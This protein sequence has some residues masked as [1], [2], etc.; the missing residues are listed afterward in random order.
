MTYAAACT[1]RLR[2]G[3]AVLIL[4]MC[5]PVPL[6]KSLGSLDQLSR[7]RLEIGLATGGGRRPFAAFGADPATF[8]ARFTEQVRLMKALWSE[9]T[10]TFAGKFWQLEDAAMEPK[11]LQRPHPP[12][13]FG[14][15]HPAAVRR[16]VRHAGGFFGAGSQTTEQFAGQV[17]VVRQE[18]DRQERDPASFRIAKRVYVAV[19]DD[20]GR[21]RE[22]M[23]AAL[24]Q[25]YGYFNLPNLLPVA[26]TGP[27]GAC[28]DG[29]RAVI[30]AGAQLILLTTLGDE[31]EQMERLAAQVIPGLG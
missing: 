22:R 29:L 2:I 10:V 12:L 19:D 11:P 30:E 20:P 25:L 26:V 3:A 18:L 9:P 13:W 27:P 23:S 14:G 15:G 24:G 7:G 21:A 17:Q 4:P 1:E 31:S 28:I 8:V 6:A 5:S 16:A